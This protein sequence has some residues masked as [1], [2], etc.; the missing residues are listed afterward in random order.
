MYIIANGC[1]VKEA[2][3][4]RVASSTKMYTL[5]F[6]ENG[7]GTKFRESRLFASIQEAKKKIS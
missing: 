2:I 3:V 1:F 6:T 5:K 4:V 7:G